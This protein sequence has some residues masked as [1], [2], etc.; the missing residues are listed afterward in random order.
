MSWQ[1]GDGSVGNRTKIPQSSHR[2]L[3]TVREVLGRVK[4]KTSS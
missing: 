4:K 2:C 3:F 1:A